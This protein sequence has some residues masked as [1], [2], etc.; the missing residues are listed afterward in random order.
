MASSILRAGGRAAAYASF[1]DTTP[2]AAAARTP[3]LEQQHSEFDAFDSVVAGGR[4]AARAA[5]AG[6]APAEKKAA[7]APAFTQ[8]NDRRTNYA[9]PNGIYT[10]PVITGSLSDTPHGPA[11]TLVKPDGTIFTGEFRNGSIRTGVCKWK[12]GDSYKGEFLDFK[13]HGEGEYTWP[14]NHRHKGNY[15]AD[16]AQGKGEETWPD[17]THYVGDFMA[18]VAHGNGVCTWP[19]GTRYSGGF[20]AGKRH[21]QGHMVS[22]DN[23]RYVCECFE[24]AYTAFRPER[25]EKRGAQKR[26]SIDTL[27]QGMVVDFLP[28]PAENRWRIA[29]IVNVTAREITVHCLTEAKGSVSNIPRR[30]VP[31][32]LAELASKSL[33]RPPSAPR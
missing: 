24:G 1:S 9:V 15:V 21:G 32:R 33:I 18:G 11:G 8:P 30:E 10:G 12:T 2:R 17:G 20:I 16:Q 3:L 28:N 26:F 6:S 14:G 13:R 29:Q 27:A 23:T 31:G 22:P 19:D 4:P 7:S 25:D 5:A